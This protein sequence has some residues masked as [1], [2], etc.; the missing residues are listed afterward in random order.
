[1]NGCLG[2]IHLPESL[3]VSLYVMTPILT[4]LLVHPERGPF[5]TKKAITEKNVEEVALPVPAKFF[6]N[7]VVTRLFG[8][9]ILRSWQCGISVSLLG[10]PC[11]LRHCLPCLQIATSASSSRSALGYSALLLVCDHPSNHVTHW[12]VYLTNLM[13]KMQ[14]EIYLKSIQY[15]GARFANFVCTIWE[16][17]GIP[18]SLAKLV[19]SFKF[20]HGIH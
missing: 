19:I 17:N 7:W 14:I 11:I 8:N 13:W 2:I 20:W 12:L 6:R 4:P 3:L 5:W 1:M 9:E 15:W 18:C 10:H 16:W